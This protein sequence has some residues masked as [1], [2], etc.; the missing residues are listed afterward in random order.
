MANPKDSIEV[1]SSKESSVK[2]TGNF[3]AARD[4]SFGDKEQ[5]SEKSKEAV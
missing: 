5:F 4:V 1:S 3:K 2:D